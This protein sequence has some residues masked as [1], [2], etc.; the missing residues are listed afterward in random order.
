MKTD[1]N[2]VFAR[3]ERLAVVIGQ[4][5]ITIVLQ[6]QEG[7]G[8]LAATVA[9]LHQLEAQHALL[10][11]QYEETQKAAVME[12]VSKLTAGLQPASAAVAEAD[13]KVKEARTTMVGADP[14]DNR[15]GPP[16][17]RSA[18]SVE[19]QGDILDRMIEAYEKE[20]QHS[21]P[22]TRRDEITRP[23]MQAALDVAK[24]EMKSVDLD[25][26]RRQLPGPRAPSDEPSRG[27]P[28]RPLI[29]DM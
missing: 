19:P 7:S 11:A 22:G 28:H 2:P 1:I 15:A 12:T 20:H 27:P 3:I 23:A 5:R 9:W 29:P 16:T 4:A 25:G 26:P 6:T 24:N 21:P 17:P 8:P 13:E 10:S 14:D 18:T